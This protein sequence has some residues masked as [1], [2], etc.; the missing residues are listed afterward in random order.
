MKRTDV[1]YGSHFEEKAVQSAQMQS[2]HVL[3]PPPPIQLNAATRMDPN[4]SM[5]VLVTTNVD[6][7]CAG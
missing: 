7:I 2:P 5:H 4:I 6:M 3:P 1:N